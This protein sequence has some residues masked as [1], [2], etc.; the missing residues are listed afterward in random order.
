VNDGENLTEE[1]WLIQSTQYKKAQ[2][3][4]KKKAFTDNSLIVFGFYFV[5]IPSCLRT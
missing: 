2:Y 1:I 3:G 4:K 5:Y